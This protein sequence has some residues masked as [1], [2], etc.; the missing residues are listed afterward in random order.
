MKPILESLVISVAVLTCSP[1]AAIAQPTEP[2][3]VDRVQQLSATVVSVDVAKRMVEL[4]SGEETKTIQVPPDVRNLAQVK[5][6]DLVVVTYHEGL[7]AE[8]K[9]P[10]ESKTVGVLDTTAATS[11]M[12]EGSKPGAAVGSKVKTTV[13]IEAV[14]RSA[15]SVTFTGPSGMI[16]TVDV[17]DPKAQQFIGTL[18]KGDHVELTYTEALAVTVEPQKKP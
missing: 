3:Q 12:P 15:N 18:K 17:V 2:V 1:L 9:R 10:G 14:D 13:V 7:G 6:G 8:F 4:R 16:R 11:R 5:P